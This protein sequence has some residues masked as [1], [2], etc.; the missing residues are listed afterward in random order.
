M[1]SMYDLVGDKIQE[2]FDAQVVDIAIYDPET[3]LINF[4]YTIER[5]VRFPNESMPFIGPRKAVLESREPLVFNVDVM[6]AVR[7]YGQTGVISGEMP[8]SA[9]YAPMISGGQ[10]RGVISLQ[11][12]DRE[13]AFDERDLSLL[14][15]LAASLSVALRTGRL[16][17][18]TRKRVSEL[19][20]INSVAMQPEARHAGDVRPGGRQD[21]GNLRRPGRRHRH[22]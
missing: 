17:D 14:T 1:Q 4:T 8:K 21:P 19:A 13:Y 10:G 12:L 22:L 6:N 9:V 18:E 7:G 20:T 5:G 3:N 11:N 15:T 2:I 16:I